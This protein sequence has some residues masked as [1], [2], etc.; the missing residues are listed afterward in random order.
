MFKT[1]NK[2]FWIFDV[3]WSLIRKQET[4]IDLT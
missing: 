2:D 1:A 3:A 4:D